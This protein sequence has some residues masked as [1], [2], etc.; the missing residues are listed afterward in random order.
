MV[1]YYG[2]FKLLFNITFRSLPAGYNDHLPHFNISVSI[3]YF[4]QYAF[5]AVDGT[6]LLIWPNIDGTFDVRVCLCLHICSWR[7]LQEQKNKKNNRNIII[8]L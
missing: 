5:Y 7:T 1:N 2:S 8:I 6:V 3:F 4:T